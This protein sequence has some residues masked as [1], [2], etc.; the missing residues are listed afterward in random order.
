MLAVCTPAIR[1]GEFR[2]AIYRCRDPKTPTAI[3]IPNG[4]FHGALCN[5]ALD[6]PGATRA[7]ME[8]LTKVV[9]PTIHL[10]GVRHVLCMMVRNS[11]IN[12]TPD[13]RTRPIFPQWACQI[14]IAYVQSLITERT[15]AVVAPTSSGR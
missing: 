14:T 4:T 10:Y 13:V 8:R 11:D 6:L 2:G 5:A 1:I 9:D 15:V 7:K 3:H 12:R